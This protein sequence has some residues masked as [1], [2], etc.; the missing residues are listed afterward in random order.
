MWR[1]TIMRDRSCEPPD[2]G[3]KHFGHQQRSVEAAEAR[4]A[5]PQGRQGFAQRGAGMAMQ[6]VLRREAGGSQRAAT[7]AWVGEQRGAQGTGT[8]GLRH[9]PGA[10]EVAR[11]E[12]AVGEHHGHAVGEQQHLARP[13]MASRR[14]SDQ[15]A[16]VAEGQGA[17]L[18]EH[19]HL[20]ARAV[21]D[22]AR[23]QRAGIGQPGVEIRGGAGQSGTEFPA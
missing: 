1:L 11:R 17:P 22:D 10:V 3:Q 12:Y 8:D 2:A 13:G 20:E 5:R 19:A 21:R 6:R 14:Q 7:D 16:L 9:V 23:G 15:R 4:A 18:G